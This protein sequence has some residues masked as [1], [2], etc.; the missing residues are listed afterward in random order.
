MSRFAVRPTQ[1]T[2]RLPFAVVRF[3]GSALGARVSCQPHL[4]TASGWKRLRRRREARAP[5]KFAW[6][7]EDA[8][9]EIA[10]P[11]PAQTRRGRPRL[12]VLTFGRGE[13]SSESEC[14]R[15]TKGFLRF[16]RDIR[17]TCVEVTRVNI[18]IGLSEMRSRS[19]NYLL[20]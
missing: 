8:T 17:S 13:A 14:G 10:W 7:V 3:A 15:S 12:G 5:R 2:T 6:K 9:A 4:G 1:Q 20:D 19:E 18:V 16:T 11:F